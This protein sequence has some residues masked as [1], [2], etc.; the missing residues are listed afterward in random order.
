MNLVT[1]ARLLTL[2]PKPL[3][4]CSRLELLAKIEEMAD[5]MIELANAIEGAGGK[6]GS[7]R[8]NG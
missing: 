7:T 5:T 4:E 3:S 6:D 1:K 8:Q 2:Q